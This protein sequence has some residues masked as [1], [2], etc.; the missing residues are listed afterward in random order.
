MS[1]IHVNF[2]GGQ[3]K[4]DVKISKGNQRLWWLT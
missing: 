1:L 3:S 2:V 4:V